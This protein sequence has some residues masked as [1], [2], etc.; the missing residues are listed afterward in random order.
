MHFQRKILGI[1]VHRKR[2]IRGIKQIIVVRRDRIVRQ[3]YVRHNI[4]LRCIADIN[5]YRQFD[6][7]PGRRLRQNHFAFVSL[8]CRFFRHRNLDVEAGFPARA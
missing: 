3:F 2:D 6:L 4:L 1:F 7:M 5:R 8:V